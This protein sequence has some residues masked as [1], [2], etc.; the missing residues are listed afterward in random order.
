MSDHLKDQGVRS[1][2]LGHDFHLC[3]TERKYLHLI[4]NCFIEPVS[5]TNS[6]YGYFYFDEDPIPTL[7]ILVFY[8]RMEIPFYKE[9]TAFI[10]KENRKCIS[11][12]KQITYIL[13]QNGIAI[14]VH[15]KFLRVYDLVTVAIYI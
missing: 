11:D 12:K 15:F 14:P 2:M 6:F 13:T 9:T 3:V 10:V 5:F 4:L 1:T 8:L 7:S